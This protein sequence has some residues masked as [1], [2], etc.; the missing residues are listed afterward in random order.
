MSFQ[1]G[2]IYNGQ[3]N[4]L[5]KKKSLKNWIHPFVTGSQK[6]DDWCPGKRILE[7]TGEVSDSRGSQVSEPNPNIGSR[8]GS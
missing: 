5:F 7:E 2:T 8:L 3:S 4:T 6:E 1:G